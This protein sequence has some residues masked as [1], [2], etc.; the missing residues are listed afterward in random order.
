[1]ITR[2]YRAES[3]INPGCGVVQGT[4]DGQVT[5]SDNG[6]GDFLGVYAYDPHYSAKAVG[7]KVGVTL[8][9][10]VPVLAGGTVHAGK[11]AALKADSS[12]TFVEADKGQATCGLFL[13]GGSA[14]E[15][16]D[17]LIERG[18]AAAEETEPET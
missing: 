9:G 6:A 4:A 15:Y 1:M 7:D 5:V 10:V 18:N 2:P 8:T 3:I 11:K 13:Q 17:L 16:V 12:G 14:G